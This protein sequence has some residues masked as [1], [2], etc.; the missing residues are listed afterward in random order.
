MELTREPQVEGV[1]CIAETGI[2][3]NQGKRCSETAVFYAQDVELSQ[4]AIEFGAVV[5]LAASG[6]ASKFG[7]P[8]ATAVAE[9]NIH[10]HTRSVGPQ[11]GKAQVKWKIS[12]ALQ[13]QAMALVVGRGA[14]LA[15]QVG[16][17]H[18]G[19]AEGDLI[20]IRV[21]EGLGKRIG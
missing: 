13:H 6:I 14:V 7:D 8:E 20:V 2:G 12:R 10:G 18:R 16:G 15:M 5:E 17:I 3:R 1:E 19:I 9:K 21:V 4:K 11:R